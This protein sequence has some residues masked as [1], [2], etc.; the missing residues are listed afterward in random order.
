LELFA[1][2]EKLTQVD[3]SGIPRE[4]SSKTTIA[5]AKEQVAN[6]LLKFKECLTI[7]AKTNLNQPSKL[8]SILLGQPDS[9]E[10][11]NEIKLLTDTL[12]EKEKA[13]E[14][15]RRDLQA[16][17]NSAN[18]LSTTN[19]NLEQAKKEMEETFRKAE[20]AVILAKELLKVAEEK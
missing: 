3:V 11:V 4:S 12:D 1:V 16:V 13:L 17:Q 14:Q 10:E 6:C 7:N 20:E 19:Q 2:G 18:L 9:Q 15:A 5:E 8:A